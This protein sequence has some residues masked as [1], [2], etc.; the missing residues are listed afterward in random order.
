[1]D[2]LVKNVINHH[3]FPIMLDVKRLTNVKLRLF[4]LWKNKKMTKVLKK[5][6]IK[7]CGQWKTG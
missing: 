5:K 1:V 7:T 4:T 2:G 6:K 3:D